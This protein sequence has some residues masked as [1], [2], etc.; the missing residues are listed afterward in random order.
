MAEQSPAFSAKSAQTA[1]E[2][3]R[4]LSDAGLSADSI[5]AHLGPDATEALY[6]GEPGAVLAA[7]DDS[8]LSGLIRFFLL[9]QPASAEQLADLLT[10][11]LALALIDAS[12]ATTT[13]SG[14]VEVVVD[15]RPHII[16]G[17]DRFVFS[18]RDAS[19]T[20]HLPGPDHVLGV[21]AASLSLLSA[22]PLTP[23]ESVLDL[24]TG[25]GVQALAQAGCADKVVATDVHPRA[26]EFAQLTLAGAEI[27]NVDIRE[28]SWFEPVT[29]ETFDRIVA[30][31]PF[32][33]G[34][35]EVGHV[36]R[37]SGLDLDG[38]SELVISHLPD[39]LA[40]NGTA[41]VLGSWVH[42]ADEPWERRV[43][44]WFPQTGVSAWVCQRDIVDPALYVSTWLKDES[45]DPRSQAGIERTRQWL[46]HFKDHGVRA[47]GFGWI[48]IREIGDAPSELTFETLDQPFTDPLGPE[49]EEYFTRMDWLRGSSQD[50][51]LNARYTLRPG[52]ALEDI[53]VADTAAGMGF[54]PEVK[55]L[56]RTDGPRF[57]HDVDDAVAAIVA[58]LNPDGLPLRDI[59]S[60]WAAAKGLDDASEEELIAE[61]AGIIVDLIRHGIVLPTDLISRHEPT[62]S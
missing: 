28:G 1:R 9:R 27:A 43:A 5:A 53:S 39:H 4:V 31:P 57:T 58:G 10:S 16:A 42:T 48:F 50:D 21:G 13:P 40:E 54:S 44:S 62:R 59:V 55:R 2:L 38:A 41:F 11:R 33:V 17:A 7:C 29:G 20:Q 60:L 14:D 45:I 6:R 30:N 8:R 56:T 51:I 34:L 47:V 24:G 23:V 12:L 18:D 25:S 15:V 35:P 61:S 46:N 52:V 49:V 36:Y 3:V 19:V 32:V 37:D 22:T 26:L